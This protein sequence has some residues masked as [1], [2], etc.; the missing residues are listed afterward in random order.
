MLKL[1]LWLKKVSWFTL[2]FNYRLRALKG[3]L[4]EILKHMGFLMQM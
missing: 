3:L 4:A 1:A 2:I